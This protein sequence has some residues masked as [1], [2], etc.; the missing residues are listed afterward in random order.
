[1]WFERASAVLGFAR[2]LSWGWVCPV[3]CGNSV[4]LPLLAGLAIGFLCGFLLALSILLYIWLHHLR[5][6]PQNS[7]PSAP[8][9]A[10]TSH[11]ARRSSRLARY[12]DEQSGFH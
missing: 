11:L 2:E 7:H 10:E 6:V 9:K 3:H 4:L 1:M 12:L 5:P 8:P